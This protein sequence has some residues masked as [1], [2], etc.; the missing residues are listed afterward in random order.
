MSAVC[1][2]GTDLAVFL[3]PERQDTERMG[4]K[5]AEKDQ[6][7]GIAL[8]ARYARPSTEVA[9]AATRSLVM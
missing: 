7:E 4:Q 2:R 1:K 3:V 9:Y 8:R 6:A 5:L